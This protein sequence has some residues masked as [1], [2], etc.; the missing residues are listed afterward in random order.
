MLKKIWK[1]LKADYTPKS[2]EILRKGY[3]LSLF[4]R[5]CISGLTV[6]I[7]SLPLAMALAIASGLTPAQGLYTAIVAGFVIALTGGSRFQ[8]GGPTGAFAIVVL[9]VLQNYGYNGL[10]AAMILTG[11]LLII[12]GFLKLGS[13]IKYIPY[14]VII[15][16]TAGIGLILI[17]S[18]VKEFLGLTRDDIPNDFIQRWYTYVVSIPQ[19]NWAAAFI[20]VLSLTLYVGIKKFTPKIPVYLAI[21]VITTVVTCVFELPVE[22]IGSKYGNLPKMLPVP[23]FPILSL[24]LFRLVFPSA[25]TV[26][27]LAAVESLLSA[28]VVD[29]MSGDMHNSNAELIGEGLANIAAAAFLGLPATGAI[30]RT[31]TNYKANAYSPVSGMM[32]SVFLL[33]FMFCLSPLVKYIPLSSLALILIMIGWNM[34][35]LDKMYG[36]IKLLPGDRYT[37]LVTVILTVVVNLSAAIA[38]GFIMS[39]V[40]F[41]HRMSKEIELANMETM[42]PD[43]GVEVAQEL[44]DK[45]IVVVRVAGPLFFGVV[46]QISEFFRQLENKPNVVIIRMGH[47]SMIDAS[48]AN[49][50]V[51]FIGKMHKTQTKVIISNIKTQPKRVLHQAFANAHVRLSDISTAS[52]Y[53]NAVKMAKRY[54]NRKIKEKAVKEA[55]AA[56]DAAV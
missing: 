27:F 3:S 17:T 30:A 2:I 33:I 39:A 6:S 31:A 47:V 20:G 43:V 45:G 24:D 1:I 29:S 50:I 54:V 16:F 18:Q 44:R 9:D 53:D 51:E 36:L 40:I 11:F 23:S 46:T 26:A 21:L 8:I 55:A 10:V 38:V 25:L 19:A 48:G 52:N 4:R 7:V 34:L 13:Y 42:V 41:M 5:D 32:Q 56:A 28:K 35:N 15:G 37:L 22:T 14:P 12:A 49:L